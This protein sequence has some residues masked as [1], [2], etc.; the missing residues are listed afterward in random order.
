MRAR[1]QKK[2]SIKSRDQRD[3]EEDEDEEEADELSVTRSY[4]T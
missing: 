3:D 2:G 4:D 1:P